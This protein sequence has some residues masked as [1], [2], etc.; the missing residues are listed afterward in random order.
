VGEI[1]ASD[2]IFGIAGRV[3]SALIDPTGA[4]RL[5]VISEHLTAPRA[6]WREEAAGSRGILGAAQG[7]GVVSS[8]KPASP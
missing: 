1:L 6:R 3:S 5:P 4:Q 2:L 7:R 8:P